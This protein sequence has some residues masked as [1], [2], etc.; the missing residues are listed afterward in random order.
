M[1]H[2]RNLTATTAVC[3]VAGGGDG[4]ERKEELPPSFHNKEVQPEDI[5]GDAL[6]QLSS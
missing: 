5:D 6:V 2:G 3:L 4:G 1:P